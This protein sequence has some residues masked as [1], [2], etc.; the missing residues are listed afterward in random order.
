MVT[1]GMRVLALVAMAFGMMTG[2]NE[3]LG[4]NERTLEVEAGPGDGGGQA[5]SGA[6]SPSDAGG[7]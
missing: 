7:G 1:R 2:C 5:E 6:D 4:V 3:I